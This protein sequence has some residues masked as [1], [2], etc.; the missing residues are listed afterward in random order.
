MTRSG[1]RTIEKRLTAW[2][3]AMEFYNSQIGMNKKSKAHKP[4]FITLTLSDKQAHDDY[5]IKRNMLQVFIKDL[6]YNFDVKHYF[7]KAE[8]QKNGN[9][10]FHILVDR[11][12]DMKHIQNAWNRIQNN[13]G[14]LEKYQKVYSHINA[15]ST[16]VEGKP[17][18]SSLIKYM[19]KY[20]SKHDNEQ[21]IEGAVFRFSKSLLKLKPFNEIVEGSFS[22]V[23]REYTDQIKTK[24]FVQDFC[25]TVYFSRD[26]RIKE[27]PTKLLAYMRNY[28]ICVYDSLYGNLEEVVITS[29]K[30][31]N[32]HLNVSTGKLFDGSDS[33]FG[34]TRL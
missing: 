5:Y 31:T 28:Y 33:Q 9:I 13:H 4:V 20:V 14:Y 25:T 23:L 8:R 16:H 18:N 17:R 29:K 10:H 21:T 34:G 27:L 12:I 11:F 22:D 3:L 19:L 32:K 6:Q 15:P 2:L 30:I 24:K 26:M 7:W 1:K